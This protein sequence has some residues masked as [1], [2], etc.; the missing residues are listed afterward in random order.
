ME[1]IFLANLR[2]F[3]FQTFTR[4]PGQ[5]KSPANIFKQF[6][7]SKNYLGFICE[8]VNLSTIIAAIELDRLLFCVRN[9]AIFS[10]QGILLNFHQELYNE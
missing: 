9:F 1:N 8:A 3:L 10:K 4:A 2:A 7:S 5:L 6:Q